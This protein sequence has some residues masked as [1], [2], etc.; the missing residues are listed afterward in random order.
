MAGRLFHIASMADRPAGFQDRIQFEVLRRLYRHSDLSQRALARD[1]D[2][3]VGSV[4]RCVQQLVTSGFLEKQGV[5]KASR[6]THYA[7]LLTPAGIARKS[8]L[9]TEFLARRI[10]E[11]EVLRQEIE[12]LRADLLVARVAGATA[13]LTT[14][15]E[16]R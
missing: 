9:T 8:A 13:E 2:I 16:S 10:A 7:Y 5:D 11:S 4:N 14:G 12:M 3:S 1:L 15:N 6:G